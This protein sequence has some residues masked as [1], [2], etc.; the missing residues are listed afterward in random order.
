MLIARI[1][2]LVNGKLVVARRKNTDPENTVKNKDK[3]K[4]RV[5]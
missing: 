5:K 1:R 4:K 2:Q 3:E